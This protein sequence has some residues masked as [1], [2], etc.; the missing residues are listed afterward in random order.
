MDTTEESHEERRQLI[1]RI[2][3][4]PITYL[5]T[6]RLKGKSCLDCVLFLQKVSQEIRADASYVID[7]PD[8]IYARFHRISNGK[9][10]HYIA[11]FTLLKNAGF[12]RIEVSA[13][14]MDFLPVG[15]VRSARKVTSRGDTVRAYLRLTTKA[16]DAVFGQRMTMGG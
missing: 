2:A 8:L 14:I 10:E 11:L 3:R 7:N 15:E 9:V 4:D 16:L 13:A 6:N 12:E 1:E 5:R